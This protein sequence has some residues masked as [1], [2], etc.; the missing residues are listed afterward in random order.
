M[1]VIGSVSLVAILGGWALIAAWRAAGRASL[2]ASRDD[3]VRESSS[4][5]RWVRRSGLPPTTVLGIQRALEPPPDSG[6]V[7][8]RSMWLS[9]VVGISAISATLTFGPA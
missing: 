8:L 2:G 5:V 3:E 4:F 6:S 1:L 9:A 7:P